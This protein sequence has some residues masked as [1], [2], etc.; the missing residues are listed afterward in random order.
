MGIN[1]KQFQSTNGEFLKPEM[2][3]KRDLVRAE[4]V[5]LAIV[6]AKGYDSEEKVPKPRLT[7]RL[8]FEPSETKVFDLNSGNVGVILEHLENSGIDTSN[9]DENAVRGLIL[10]L[11]VIPQ[12]KAKS[13][14]SIAIAISSDQSPITAKSISAKPDKLIDTV[15]SEEIFDF[16]L[17]N[18]ER[19]MAKIQPHAVLD[20]VTKMYGYPTEQYGIVKLWP[21]SAL[22]KQNAK[23]L[24]NYEIKLM[25][26]VRLIESGNEVIDEL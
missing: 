14:K 21:M 1:L 12:P 8:D 16:D 9:F 23:Q 26:C 10:R 6:E 25:A 22:A 4:I 18:I 11:T 19:L 17:K 13:G 20:T 5:S 24:S 7:L 3:A 2:L 15:A